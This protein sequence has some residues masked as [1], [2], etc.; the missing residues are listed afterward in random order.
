MLR[1]RSNAVTTKTA[2]M[3]DQNSPIST[4]LGSPRIFHG[5]LTK[6]LSHA[7]ITI[8]SPTS[9]LE[10]KN[11]SNFENPYGYKQNLT[12][13][14]TIEI[15]NPFDNKK[16]EPKA[17]G[18]AL[19]DS[20]IEEKNDTNFSKPI[21]R[22]AL[23]G[24]KLKV[25]IPTINP[26]SDL[27]SPVDFGIKTKNSQTL[28]P[29]CEAPSKKDFSRQLSLKEMELSEDYTCVITHGPKP[30]TTHIFGNCIV[31]CCCGEENFISVDPNNDFHMHREEKGFCRHE[32]PHQEM[33]FDG[34][35]KNKV[36]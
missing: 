18:L 9:T 11:S 34:T 5:L 2:L 19:I 33:D 17:I 27:L 30:K 13:K 20:L 25:Q 14:T 32:C 3:A 8:L 23:F 15:N 31:E 10:T 29:F 12:Q 4:F 28:S 1:N 24:S 7:E 22:M 36:G 6:S 26:S 35:E 16:S 21:N